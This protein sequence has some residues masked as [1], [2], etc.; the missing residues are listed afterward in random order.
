M[1]VR[2]GGQLYDVSVGGGRGVLT[3]QR[4]RLSRPG[5]V[6]RCGRI[7]EAAFRK[8]CRESR[9]F[10]SLQYKLSGLTHGPKHLRPR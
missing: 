1:F 8:T 5:G 7:L 3:A 4:P 2:V 6:D 10:C 9:R